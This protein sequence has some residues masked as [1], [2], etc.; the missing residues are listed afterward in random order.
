MVPFRTFRGPLSPNQELFLSVSYS[1]PALV[2]PLPPYSA[3]T[4]S[5]QHLLALRLTQL[6]KTTCA[7]SLLSQRSRITEAEQG[8][9]PDLTLT[10]CTNR[11]NRMEFSAGVGLVLRDASMNKTH[12]LILEISRSNK[13]YDLLTVIDLLFQ[14]GKYYHNPHT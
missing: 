8:S 6:N 4:D 2:L 13:R 11:R 5:R 1:K 10:Q 14:I 9:L 3:N 7:P 12:S